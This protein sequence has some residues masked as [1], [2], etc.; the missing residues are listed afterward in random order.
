MPA[1]TKVLPAD[2]I[3]AATHDD[4]RG[5]YAALAG[6][7]MFFDAALDCWVTSAADVVT[8]IL[9]HPS[10]RVRPPAEP[11][12]QSLQ[13]SAAGRIFAALVRMTDG[14]AHG[15][16][17]Q[18]IS[19]ALDSVSEAQI[20]QSAIDVMPALAL[21]AR[22]DGAQ[23]TR[24]SYALPTVVLA[25]WIGIPQADWP[26]LIDEVL[27]FVRCVAPGGSEMDMRAGIQAASRLEQRVR[28]QLS[29]PGP[30]LQR[31]DAEIARSGLPDGEALLVANAIGLWFQ[32]CEGC[33]GL[34]GL[35]L[36]A[37]HSNP[38]PSPSPSPS[39]Q[40]AADW[41]DAVLDDLPPIQNTRRFAAADA[42]IAGCPLHAGDR[43]LSVLASQG[44]GM[45]HSHAFGY[46]PHACP[47]ASWARTLAVAGIE[48]VLQS[49]VTEEVLAQYAWRRSANAR[50]PEFY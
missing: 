10:L 37:A 27:A 12:P 17:K 34:I 32:A 7:G 48:Y 18:A 39:G 19:A 1:N 3:A 49:G 13:D 40:R 22:P 2:A 26:E 35:S 24:F 31:L 28:A 11:V 25:H 23:I 36:L 4:P 50:V 45:A 15:P 8:E 29:A 6:Q 46:G 41:V 5:Y 44:E 20:R 14:P 38:N 33:A 30:L 47:G 43:V 9:D 42:V 16:L 21:P